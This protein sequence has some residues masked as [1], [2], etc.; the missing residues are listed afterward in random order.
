[1]AN[2]ASWRENCA[3]TDLV[4]YYNRLTALMDKGRV[5]GIIYLDLCKAFN[6]VPNNILVSKLERRGFDGW[7]T[8]L[9]GQ[10]GWLHSKSCSQWLNVQVEASE[11]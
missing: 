3:W 10:T 2:M 6:T 9:I 11:E 8:W 7:T 1:M 5:T 4:A